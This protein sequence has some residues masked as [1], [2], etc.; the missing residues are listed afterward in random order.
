M[1]RRHW[2]KAN[3]P[4][5]ISTSSLSKQNTAPE[6]TLIDKCDFVNFKKS[7]VASDLSKEQKVE[8]LKQVDD[9]IE[10]NLKKVKP[11]F[12]GQ[13]PILKQGKNIKFLKNYNIRKL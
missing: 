10:E 1:R 13:V 5:P 11:F 7:Y 12:G 4:K 3:T 9:V 8:L 2:M 6:Q